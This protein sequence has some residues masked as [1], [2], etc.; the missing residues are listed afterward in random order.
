MST[1]NGHRPAWRRRFTGVTTGLAA[2]AALAALT[3]PSAGAQEPTSNDTSRAT[4]E[5]GTTTAATTTEEATALV[6]V[7]REDFEGAAGSPPS[8]ENWI[9]DTGTS[10][11]G[12]PANW[13]TGERQTYTDSPENLK[14][15][16]NGNLSITALRDGGGGWSSGRIETQRTDFAA[17]DGGL[18]RIEAR[19]QLPN[20]S[21]DAALGYWPAFWTLGAEYRGN[22]WNWP[23]IGEFDI[24]EN[25]NGVDQTWGVLHCGVSPGGPCDETNGLGSSLACSDCGT[26]FHEYALE[27]DRTGEVEYLRWYRDGQEFHSVSS[28]QVGA[29]TWANATDHG[30]FILLN[31]AMGGAFPDG[32]AGFATPTDATVPG[33]S[34]LVDYVSVSVQ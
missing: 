5:T 22:Y 19:M 23:G 29:E 2:L 26:G 1:E 28:D 18:M 21:G 27:L 20:V 12:G 30:H 15:D 3:L 6:E 32:V 10:Y 7:W 11:P 34:L 16:G 4:L 17:P 31:L 14:L 24:M 9:I 25:V 8:S 33:A 13:G